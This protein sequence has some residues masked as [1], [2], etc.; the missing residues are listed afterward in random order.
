[1]D[2]LSLYTKAE[3]QFGINLAIDSRDTKSPAEWWSL[4]GN[5]APTLQKFAIKIL[6]LACSASGCE[7]NWS[8]FEHIHSK[9]RNK[10]EHERLQKLVFIK[11]NQKLKNRFKR[12]DLIDPI[13]LEDIDDSNEWMTGFMENN[14]DAEEDLVFEDDS[15]TWGVVQR[16]SGAGEMA[17]LTRQHHRV[18]KS[19]GKKKASSSTPIRNEED[20]NFDDIWEEDDLDYNS[21]E[22]EDYGRDLEEEEEEEDESF[23]VDDLSD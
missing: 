16:A 14:S 3:G 12:K 10:L 11:Y 13:S 19:K 8:V 6:S 18:T 23:D 4:Y 15:L 17:H 21:K 7:R 22:D 20:A 5:S 9:K 2:E 1:M